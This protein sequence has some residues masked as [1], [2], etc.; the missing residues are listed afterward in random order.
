M[1]CRLVQSIL[2]VVEKIS[3]RAFCVNL[4]YCFSVFDFYLSRAD[5]TVLLNS[6]VLHVME[7]VKQVHQSIKSPVCS[8]ASW[9]NFS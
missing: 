1:V 8:P 3:M 2:A 9:P 4:G 7:N 6:G 5:A